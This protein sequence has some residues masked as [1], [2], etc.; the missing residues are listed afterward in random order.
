MSQIARVNARQIL[1]SRGQPTVEVEVGL[2]SGAVGRAAVPSGASTGAFEALELRDGDSSAYAGK[3][4]MKA[5]A[6]V[7]DELAGVLVGRDAS[8]QAVIDRTMIEFDGTPNKARLGAN[9]ILG[10]SLAV[11]QAA[12]ADARLPLYRY[13]GGARANRLPVPLM[14]ILN[15][16]AHADNSVDLQ[17]FMV[18]PVGARTLADAVRMGAEVYG[19]LKTVLRGRGLGTGV[20]D[21]GGF[22]PDLESNQ[23]A[24]DVIMEAIVA[25]GYT[26]GEEIALALDPA[27]TELYRDGAYHLEG[28]GRTLDSAGMVDYWADLVDRYPIV[29]IEDGMAEEDWDG[30]VALTER[31]GDRVQLV[32]D[33][34]FVTN[35]RRLARGIELGA[36]NAL[37]VKVNQIG[38]LSETLAA[39]DLASRSGYASMVSHRSGETEDTF[40]ADLAVAT[41]AG[42]IKT[43]AP[44][45]SERV[46]KYNQLIRIEEQLGPAASYPG[47]SAFR[48]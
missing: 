4:V 3:G 15:G 45:R 10:C 8:A 14:N 18:A 36:A 2:V 29:S 27:T 39:M 1:D 11:A 41:G 31:L 20:G 47:R 17:E 40:I 34:L 23:A 37:L 44:S 9:A 24:L 26:P 21:E 33:D 25:A 32:G 30:W 7:E 16:G 46:A 28:E 35:S 6:N 43:G 48:A 22:A 12:A 42:Q 5:V 13:L 38:T 19:A